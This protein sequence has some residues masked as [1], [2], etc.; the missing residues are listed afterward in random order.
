MAFG[1]IAFPGPRLVSLLSV[2]SDCSARWQ[3]TNELSPKA[4]TNSTTGSDAEK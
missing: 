3:L 4:V 2:C 1:G